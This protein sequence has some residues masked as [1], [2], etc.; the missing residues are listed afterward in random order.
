[1]ERRFKWA[2]LRDYA[3][4]PLEDEARPDLELFALAPEQKLQGQ[5]LLHEAARLFDDAAEAFSRLRDRGAVASG[6]ELCHDS[7]QE[8]CH[9]APPWDSYLTVTAPRYRS[10]FLTLLKCARAILV[11]CGWHRRIRMR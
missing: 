3:V 8:V 9:T 4:I 7:F 5:E 1:M 6:S 2:F 11:F 10:L